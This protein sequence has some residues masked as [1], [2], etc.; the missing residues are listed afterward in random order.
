MRVGPSDTTRGKVVVVS[1]A[2]YC[3]HEK[4]DFPVSLCTGLPEVWHRA[5]LL[6]RTEI[7]LFGKKIANKVAF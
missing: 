4:Y 5:E 6:Q 1:E 2:Y 7:R 3:F